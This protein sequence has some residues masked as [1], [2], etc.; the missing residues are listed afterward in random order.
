MDCLAIFQ[1]QYLALLL[2]SVH[3][4]N[5]TYVQGPYCAGLRYQAFMRK[6]GRGC[7]LG[8]EGRWS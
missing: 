5:L 1:G 6:Q 3:I 2:D 8:R 7:I 4:G